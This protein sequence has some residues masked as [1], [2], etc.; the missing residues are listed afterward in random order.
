MKG[1]GDAQDTIYTCLH[2]SGNILEK[3]GVKEQ[4]GY[5][6]T[7]F[8]QLD[9]AKDYFPS[10][11][12][13]IPDSVTIPINKDLVTKTKTGIYPDSATSTERLVSLTA[14]TKAS[15]SGACVSGIEDTWLFNSLNCTD[16][17]YGN[18]YRF[19]D[20]DAGGIPNP[21]CVGLNEYA[22]RNIGA[23][24]LASH[25]ATCPQVNSQ[26]QD[27][28]VRSFVNNFLTQRTQV[29]SLMGT[30]ETKINTIQTKNTQ[31]MDALFQITAPFDSING[32]IRQLHSALADKQ[33][34]IL[35]NAKCTFIKTGL[36]NFYNAMCVGFISSIYQTAV[37]IIIV[38]MFAFF[39][40][41]FVFCFAKRA[42][43]PEDDEEK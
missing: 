33:N 2:G 24:Y 8:E 3:L 32:N 12:G 38:S 13:T 6:D 17:S 11:R 16:G 22:G 35:A 14:R 10:S 23:R 28:Y 1:G 34:G 40:T 21:T 41:F 31:F 7:I 30:L 9:K 37:C 42:V 20:G 26:N 43:I 27:V 5:F 25:Y 29:T 19:A 39:G 4:L 15:A 18:T 36:K